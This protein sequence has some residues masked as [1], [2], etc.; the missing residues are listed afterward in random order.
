MQK[1]CDILYIQY[2]KEACIMMLCWLNKCHLLP[3]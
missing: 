2:K 1:Q 3:T